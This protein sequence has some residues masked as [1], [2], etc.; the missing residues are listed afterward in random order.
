[1]VATG[2]PSISPTKK[3]FASGIAK[4]AASERPG[5]QP[6]AAAH[7]TAMA[8][9]SGRKLRIC[10]SLIFKSLSTVDLPAG[11]AVEGLMIGR[12]CGSPHDIIEDDRSWQQ[13]W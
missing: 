2:S 13:R 10:K 1:M 6:S 3:P 11:P 9:S 7:S 5:F 8:I 4:Q 12:A